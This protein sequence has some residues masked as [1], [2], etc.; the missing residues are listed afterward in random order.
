MEMKDR[1]KTLL[2]IED[3]EQDAVLDIII[4][5]IE[6]HLLHKLKKSDDS[7]EEIPNDLNY[8]IVEIAVKRFNRLGSEGYQS[9][10]V[11]GHSVTFAEMDEYFA[12][13]SDVIDDVAGRG[14]VRFI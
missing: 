7:I 1:V 11:E 6:N 3:G 4:E 9:E 8:I 12:P 5:N 10:S 13:Y 2:G 14:R